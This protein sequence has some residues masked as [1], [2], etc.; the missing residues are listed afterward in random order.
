MQDLIGVWQRQTRRYA[1]EALA[2]Y[3][4]YAELDRGWQRQTRQFTTE[5]LAEYAE[6][7]ERHEGEST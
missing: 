4:E 1:I 5:G 2:E 6:Y 3:A 7:A